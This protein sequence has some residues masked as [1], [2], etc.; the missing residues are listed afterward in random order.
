MPLWIIDTQPANRHGGVADP[1]I[2]VI[3]ELGHEAVETYHNSDKGIAPS[4][5]LPLLQSNRPMILRGSVGF[6]RWAHAQ[7]PPHPG[8]FPSEGAKPSAWISAYGDLSLN[9]GAVIVPYGEFEQDRATYEDKYGG[10]LFIK[11]A[12]DGK[13]LSGTVV[14]P[15]HQLF[16]VHFSYSLAP[17]SRRS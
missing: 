8:G 14:Q 16:D 5:L 7:G 17:A 11:P 10:P 3:H 4:E 2:E 15:G 1:I 12:D 6:I 9:A 13:M